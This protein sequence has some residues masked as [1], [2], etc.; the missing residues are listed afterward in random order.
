MRR[1]IVQLSGYGPAVL[2]DALHVG[3]DN[4]RTGQTVARMKLAIERGAHDSEVQKLARQI[5]SV[6]PARATDHERAAAIWSWVKN[7]IRFVDDPPY[8]ELLIE[9]AL[10][11]RLP[12]NRRAGDCDD[13]S[14]LGGALLRVLGYIPRI[15]TIRADAR[16]P[17]RFSHVFLE[18]ELPDGARVPFDASH[19]EFFGWRAPAYFSSFNWGH[20]MGA[21]G[22]AQYVRTPAGLAG[23]LDDLLGTGLRIGEQ[24][25]GAFATRIAVP[26]NTYSSRTA[27]GDVVMARGA[28]S[29]T[30]AA[31]S[32]GIPSIGTGG[33][34]NIVP[35][36]LGA[37]VVMGALT[38]F[39]R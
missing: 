38:V 39:K 16:D 30:A 17:S 28:P 15:E 20:G 29:V 1:S 35:W 18:V 10:M 25:G 2:E 27:A 9:P 37:V 24:I 7:N 32:V 19:G 6:L 11:V 34:I 8:D 31:A 23:P 3:D 26:P 14:M 33:E 4:A 21:L 5:V 36:I 12:A 13:F 22:R